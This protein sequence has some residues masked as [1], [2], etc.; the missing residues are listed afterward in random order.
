MNK[1]L[2]SF[3]TFSLL[4][5][6][7]FADPAPDFTALVKQTKDSVVSIEVS[8]KVQDSRQMSGFSG[9][10]PDIFEHFFGIPS[11][12]SYQPY[13][14][15]FAEPAPKPRLQ[16][17]QGSGFIIDEQGYLLTN[18]H[19]VDDAESVTVKLNTQR[20]YRA[21]VIGLD[22]TTDIALLKI[23]AE[24]LPAATL[25]DSDKVEVGDWVLAMGSPFGFD[26]TATQGIV[27]A[28]ARSLPSGVYVPFIQTD[29]AINPGNSGGPLFN[30]KG[31]VIAINSQIYSRSGAFNGL[32]FS[33]PINVAKN[34]AE[35]LK[36]GGEVSR[37][38]L[39]VGIQ[40]IDQQLAES[41][42]MDSPRGA[43]VTKVMEDSPA[44]QAKIKTG[45]VILKL[46]ERVI[47]KSAD[48]P[49]MVAILPAGEAV[50]L[51]I[52]R[53]GKEQQLSLTIGN[54]NK[55]LKEG[56]GGSKAAMNR[57]WG[58]R[59]QALSEDE[60]AQ[61]RFSGKEGVL[62]AE[63]QADSA[64]QEA[65]LRAGDILLAVR[66]RL[67]SDVDE[68]AALLA[69]APNDRPLPVLI[70]RNGVST[71]LALTPKK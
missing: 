60:R 31:E 10:I 62:I 23:E 47:A 53:D 48:L 38:W 42:G 64:A 43:L 4:S 30:S 15:P 45:D 29:A 46:N 65:G 6:S 16:Q 41:F 22:E 50:Q 18:A 49:P 14:S 34:V 9:E 66:D 51:T 35:Q 61:L 32:A 17:V 70:Y 28:T 3:L 36:A 11:P 52:L 56:K 19:V 20:E 39:G 7:A 54:A 40:N 13:G 58:L 57:Q 68:A 67:L 27:S 25:G 71:Y 1:P 21:E 44:E 63:V 37:G 12:R 55:A 26:Y 59:L 24:H 8:S 5:V 2:V 69:K 33:I